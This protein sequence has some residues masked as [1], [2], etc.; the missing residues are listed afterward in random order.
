[1]F[2]KLLHNQS[3]HD[4]KR[5]RNHRFVVAN[6][7]WLSQVIAADPPTYEYPEYRHFRFGTWPDKNVNDPP[8][9]GVPHATAPPEISLSLQEL[10]I[11]FVNFVS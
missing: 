6:P 1:M 7:F 8:N 10:Q 4:A 2:R 11:E 5:T 9:S 3:P